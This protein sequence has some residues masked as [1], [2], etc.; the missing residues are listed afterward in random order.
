MPEKISICSDR[1]S[2]ESVGN[3]VYVVCARK[4]KWLGWRKDRKS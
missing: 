2:K 3:D 4:L 1:G